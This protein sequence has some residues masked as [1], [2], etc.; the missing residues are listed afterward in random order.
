[1][2]GFIERLLIVDDNKEVR[3][4]L[5]MQ[6]E[7]HNEVEC[8][9]ASDGA[10]ALNILNEFQVHVVV[11][12]LNMPNLN[13]YEFSEQL[14]A[15]FP[16]IDIV[17]ISGELSVRDFERLL[18]IGVRKLFRKPC[19]LSVVAQDI[20]HMLESKIVQEMEGMFLDHLFREQASIESFSSKSLQDKA[21][22]LAS[23]IE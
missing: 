7:E 1:M 3:E 2:E 6:F 8:F 14:R 13:G 4:T 12:D 16:R 21:K 18:E 22:I 23:F 15:K 17:V 5:L 19:E 10:E 11:T 20:K 9:L